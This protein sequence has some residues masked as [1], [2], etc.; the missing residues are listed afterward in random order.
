ME[1]KR[2]IRIADSY[3]LMRPILFFPVW[4]IFQVGFIRASLYKKESWF[5]FHFLN[6][7]W[8][9]ESLYF[10]ILVTVLCGGIFILNQVQDI[11]TDKQNDKLFLIANNYISERW[12]NVEGIIL[13]A[14]SLGMAFFSSW[15]QGVIFLFLF[16]ITG[17]FY[18]YSPF[19]WKDK[20]FPGLFANAMAGLLIFVSGWCTQLSFSRESILYSMPY[21]F[22]IST[23]YIYTTIPDR[24]GDE[25]ANKMTY[26]VVLGYK[27]ATRLALVLGII[28]LIFSILLKDWMMTLA[29][30]G[31]LIFFVK[32]S[33][34]QN[35]ND[36]S[37]ATKLPILFLAIGVCWKIP[38]YVV[39]I[40]INLYLTKL[41]YRYRFRL[42]YPQFSRLDTSLN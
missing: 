35:D 14:V 17:W 7:F 5:N 30:L 21:V 25:A 3:F 40:F 32:V 24:I 1:L 4:T 42:K 28:T 12:A 2:L 33:Q 15:I 22:A 10:G 23:I 27:K 11:E 41:Y 39:L 13:I 20:T 6:D 34:T 29:T 16:I 26:A 19:N 31:S 8:Q 9:G 37:L 36:L 18:S 38:G